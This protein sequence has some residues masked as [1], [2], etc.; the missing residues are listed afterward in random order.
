MLSANAAS[1]CSIDP[2]WRPEIL[3]FILTFFK[4]AFITK[5]KSNGDREYT[6]LVQLEI[7]KGD[8]RT[9]FT[10]DWAVKPLYKAAI[11]ALIPS[12]V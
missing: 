3:G 9:W 10:F 11:H 12:P 6:L 4:K 8:E 2:T 7:V 5:I 1:L